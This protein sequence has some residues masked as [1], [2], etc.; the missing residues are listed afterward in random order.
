MFSWETELDWNDEAVEPDITLRHHCGALQRPD[1]AMTGELVLWCPKC[2]LN[3]VVPRRKMEQEPA[4]PA[5]HR[6]IGGDGRCTE[7][8]EAGVCDAPVH[9]RGLCKVHYLRWWRQSRAEK[10]DT[11]RRVPVAMV[12]EPVDVRGFIRGLANDASWMMV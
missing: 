6:E 5:R 2:Q 3:E 10:K 9:G 12:V 4:A 7:A 8:L 11:R 1:V